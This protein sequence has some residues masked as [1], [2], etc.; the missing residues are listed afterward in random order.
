MK[1]IQVTRPFLPPQSEYLQLVDWQFLDRNWLTND[2]PL[3]RE[4]ESKVSD[5][6]GAQE[7]VFVSNGT[8]ALQLA[9]RALD[10]RGEVLTTP[11][12]YVAT[13]TSILWEQCTPVFVDIEPNGFNLDPSQ[14]E[15]HITERTSAILATHCFGIACDIDRIQEIAN[16]HGLKVIYDGA[17]CF[18]ASYRGQTF[19]ILAT[20]QP[21]VFTRLKS[22]TPWKGAACSWMTGLGKRRAFCGTLA[23]TV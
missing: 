9:L 5:W 6:L 8:I 7:M 23:M 18:G 4:L 14:L 1:D 16:R 21:A 19:S 11:F 2:G 20:C 17:H 12:S 13:T 15:R 3:V 10:C 22:F